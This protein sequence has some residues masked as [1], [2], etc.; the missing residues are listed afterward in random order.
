MI[1][2]FDV[3]SYRTNA[4][5]NRRTEGES[6]RPEL[7]THRPKGLTW[8]KGYRRPSDPLLEEQMPDRLMSSSVGRDSGIGL[9]EFGAD[10]IEANISSKSLAFRRAAHEQVCPV[11]RRIV[12]DV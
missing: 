2:E 9:G 3:P 5:Q 8:I 6:D 11:L 7:L 10:S 1:L 12:P 4:A